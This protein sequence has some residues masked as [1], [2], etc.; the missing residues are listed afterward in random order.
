MLK[1]CWK[2]FYITRLFWIPAPFFFVLLLSTFIFS[3]LLFLA[4]AV[5]LTFFMAI[6][7]PLIED[8]YRT[9][10]IIASF[11]ISHQSVVIA[12]YLTSFFI[13]IIGMILFFASG[14]LYSSLFSENQ[15][16]L[17]SMASFEGGILF[18]GF[19][20]LFMIL[21]FPL[22]FRLG[23]GKALFAF[24]AFLTALSAVMWLL[25]KI[26]VLITG[27]SLF[28]IK[29]MQA[30][31]IKSPVLYFSKWIINL[32]DGIGPAPFILLLVII[33][34]GIVGASISL[35]IKFYKSKEK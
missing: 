18:L 35:S 10:Q 3:K 32:K 29:N 1:L 15:I 13:I 16:D 24:P 28:P 19:S 9:E 14:L 21:F 22:N 6:S 26:L 23:V 30:N 20:L 27:K 8:H 17:K 7:I 34:T 12:R 25:N 4:A 2:D 31:I 11:S 33:L 5:I